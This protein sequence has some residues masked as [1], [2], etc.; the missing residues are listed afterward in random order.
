MTSPGSMYGRVGEV[1]T[2]TESIDG[3]LSRCLIKF[4]NSSV[5]MWFSDYEIDK[6]EKE[7]KFNVGDAVQIGEHKNRSYRVTKVYTNGDID[8]HL[9]GNP[10]KVWINVAADLFVLVRSAGE[11]ACPACGHPTQP[12]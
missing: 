10:S 5:S 9:I 3:D 8:I 7:P 1:T 2:T 12:A 6:V 11:P 4:P